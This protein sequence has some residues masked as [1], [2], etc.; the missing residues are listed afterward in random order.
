MKK[1][2][3]FKRILSFALILCMLSS[4]AVPAAA[5]EETG[6]RFE[7]I[8][9][10][11]VKG[12]PIQEEPVDVSASAEQYGDEDIVRVSIVVDG[13]S[14][15]DAGYSTSDIL[16]N[17]AALKHMDKVKKNQKN[18]EKKIEKALGKKLKVQRN[19][20][21]AANIISAD[22]AYGDISAI[23]SVSGVSQVVLETRYAPCE[24]TADPN[25]AIASQNM[26][27][28]KQAWADGYTG[29][30]ARIAIIDTG[31]DIDHQS[32]DNDAFLYALEQD[33]KA[34]GKKLT[35]YLSSTINL[36][37]AKEIS[38]AL[39]YLNAAAAYGSGLTAGDVMISEKI[40]F[41]FNYVDVNTNV[42]HLYDTQGEHG[43]HVSGI[44]T[45]NRYIR[46]EEGFADAIGTVG[47]AGN[48]PDAQILVMKVFGASGGAYDSD[49]MAAI[50][51][52]I[53]LG[54]DSVNL[55]LGSSAAGMTTS[56]TYQEILDKL[57]STDTV[58]VMSAGNSGSWAD[59]TY[60]G[61]LW[62]DDI[63]FMTGG[64][65]G[66]YTNSFTVASVQN[67]GVVGYSFC[68]AG[69]D[70][71]YTESATYGNQPLTRLAGDGE[72][73]Y[74]YVFLDAIGQESDYVGID[75]AGK[76]VF[77]RRGS[78]SFYEKANIAASKGAVA[79]II[80][81]NQP[82]TIG[83]NLTG[84]KY[85][86]PCVS[87]TQQASADIQAAST[88][89]VADNGT[90]YYTGT[91]TISNAV[92][93]VFDNAEYFTM[94]SFSSWGVP[95]DL[96]L[97][98]EITAP[99]GNIYS[100]AGTYQDVD[101]YYGGTDQYE[102]M[103]GT[104]MAAPQI[105]GMTAVL[106]RYIEQNGLGRKAL[107]DRALAQSLLMSTAAPMVSPDGYLYSVMQ[108]GAG[109][110]NISDAMNAATYI[111]MNADATASAADG[112]VKAELGDDPEK[113][114]VYSFGFTMTNLSKK[115]QTYA[116][117]A[118]VFTQAT[119]GLCLYGDT[120]GIYADVTFLVNGKAADSVTVKK[121]GST[122]VQVIIT[123]TDDTKA[124]F[125]TY[126][127][128][129][130]YV[131]A[132]IY[133]DPVKG[134]SA[135]HSIPVLAYYGNWTD[136]SMFDNG[137][138]VEYKYG[139]ETLPP[140]LSE[141]NGTS[142]NAYT[143]RFADGGEYYFAGNLYAKESAYDPQR[144]ALNNQNGDAISSV[145]YSLIRNAGTRTMTISNAETGEVYAAGT[146]GSQYAAYFHDG[147]ATWK[148][149]QYKVGLNWAGT[150]AEGN[151]L[152]EGTTVVLNL[153]AAPEYYRNADGSYDLSGLGDGASFTT[154]LTIDNT[155]PVLE[156]V[157]N[158]EAGSI[159]VSVSDNQYIAAI[160][161]Y[162]AD[163]E[164]LV[165][166][167]AVGVP[168]VTAPLGSG[169]DADVYLVQAIDYAGN[170]STYRVFLNTEPTE[171]VESVSISDTSL[172]LVKN[173]SAV[174]TAKAEPKTLTSREVT[175]TSSDESVATVS[176]DGTVYAVGAGDCVIT[177]ASAVDPQVTAQCLVQ[178]VEI[179]VD[180]NAA[181]WDEDGLVW[182]SQFNTSSL[183]EYTKLAQAPDN[184]PVNAMAY[185]ADGTLYASDLDTNAGVSNLYTVDPASFGLNL[186][187]T[188]SIAYTDLA[189][190]PNLGNVLMGTYFNYVVV[191]DASTGD[192]LGA[193]NYCSNELVG[194]TYAGS[195]FNSYYGQYLDIYYMLDSE[196]NLYQDAFINL[197][198]AYYYFFGQEDALMGSTGITTDT[199][200]FQSLY[201]D[202]QFIFASCFN[203]SKNSV[204]LYAIDIGNTGGIFSMGSFDDGVW[205]A[206]ALIQIAPGEMEAT[207][208]AADALTEAEVLAQATDV[209][210]EA[211]SMTVGK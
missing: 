103:S 26:T 96:S 211:F 61:E 21:L 110:A 51:D 124:F 136:P 195:V 133:A 32:F 92:S 116:L 169:L 191:V 143:V 29:A 205:P 15:M 38:K 100:V 117:S 55:S 201:Y 142:G 196:G 6:I 128:N 1:Q 54:C 153:T 135:A 56:A 119:D 156:A 187:G 125:D 76:V 115:N 71:A 36:L 113:T 127:A 24:A 208:S 168:S 72:A 59:N 70:Y 176:Q 83:L 77:C 177:A 68:I 88:A 23:E 14:V 27:G 150:D 60:Y 84:Y 148:N 164:A 81:N 189:P 67:D 75:V 165:G 50:E 78:T 73:D 140:Y 42:T 79:V 209:V 163:G 126:L 170:I 179:S 91:I 102:L 25:M 34:A 45:A 86:A 48:A 97:K 155:A 53:V 98:P 31:L 178:V 193:F 139:L 105:T 192:Y 181:V 200:Y 39:P 22:V 43:S 145:Y 185:G 190:A 131:E 172:L 17:S 151:P 41:A 206:A 161:L 16:N 210:P 112:K 180:L 122:S 174:L 188:S 109:L 11:A 33:A 95:G 87:I 146:L 132:Y 13:D 47:V 130:A 114:G 120:M 171:T 149:T 74:P 197:D 144:N 44:A 175:W 199:P 118:D 160:L 159:T 90:T 182:F 204:T 9:N 62:S 19:L 111:T 8:D 80:C 173:N 5:A 108:Q 52:A 57:T 40:P 106:K 7:Q 10:S 4:F 63:G 64:S 157:A 137:S 99:G 93:P 203:E 152:P 141:V 138:Y 2:S 20:T 184:A 202:G 183:P 35:P 154:Q 134:D 82:G 30:G 58:V 66:T 198:G 207:G 186:V 194:I 69:A 46:T 123:L 65:P 107:T 28:A 129:G 167:A 104:S 121:N 162:S 12:S 3:V 49:Y 158:D 18:L 37:G 101:G 166:R 147:T 94:S 89:A 85:T